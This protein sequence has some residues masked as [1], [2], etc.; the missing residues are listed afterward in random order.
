MNKVI[1]FLKKWIPKGALIPFGIVF[2]YQCF[3]YFI[4]QIFVVKKDCYDFTT[5]FDRQVPLIPQFVYIY[6]ICYVFWIVNEMIAGVVSKEHFYNGLT[7]SIIGNTIATITFILVPTTIVR[8][9][10]ADTGLSNWILQFVYN[11]DQPVNLFPSIHCFVSWLCYII[12]RKQSAFSKGYR[13]FSF[14]FAV[15]I[16]ISTQVLKQ[17]YIVDAI[18]GIFMAELLWIIVSKGN[19]Y[20]PVMQL[21]EGI[22]RRLKIDW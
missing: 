22:N 13:I 8:P 21:F 20:K 10:L 5:Y 2:T 15:L 16:C 7:V 19:L 18:S 14:I 6:L 11:M 4:T 12:V 9:D 17:H 3:G 1:Y